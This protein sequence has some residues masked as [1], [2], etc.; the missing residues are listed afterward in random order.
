MQI[1]S[2]PGYSAVF[3]FECKDWSKPVGKGHV[4][5]LGAKMHRLGAQ[6]AFFIAPK[7][8]ADA[9]ASA[10]Q[11]PKVIL[12]EAEKSDSSPSGRT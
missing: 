10:A 7:F 11:S 3:L 1:D 2:A 5:G 4:D 9:Y 8:T 12:R 6:T